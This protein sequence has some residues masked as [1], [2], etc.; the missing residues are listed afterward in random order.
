MMCL[1]VV[2][3]ADSTVYRTDGPEMTID[4][5]PAELSSTTSINSSG[6]LLK[7]RRDGDG[8]ASSSVLRVEGKTVTHHCC[9]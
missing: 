4:S 3:S 9:K 5:Q 2:A 6:V 1:P 8:S 7:T